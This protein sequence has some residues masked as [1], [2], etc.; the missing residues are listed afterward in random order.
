MV[1]NVGKNRA[2]E[3]ACVWNVKDA[4]ISHGFCEFWEPRHEISSWNVM[5]YSVTMTEYG[6]RWERSMILHLLPHHS[7]QEPTHRHHEPASGSLKY[8]Q[9]RGTN[10]PSQVKVPLLF[11]PSLC[12]PMSQPQKSQE[13]ETRKKERE[14]TALKNTTA[15]S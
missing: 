11:H 1:F 14:R 3:T 10:N 5:S 7:S 8:Q 15:L 2:V 4:Y 13:L 9:P 12:L 6:E